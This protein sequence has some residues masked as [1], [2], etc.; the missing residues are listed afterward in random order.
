MKDELCTGLPKKDETL[1]T[2]VK[3]LLI[4][5]LKYPFTCHTGFFFSNLIY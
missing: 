2:I 3:I 5:F 4:C 1:E